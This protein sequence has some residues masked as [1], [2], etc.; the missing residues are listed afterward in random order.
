MSDV[1]S[2]PSACASSVSRSPIGHIDDLVLPWG[3]VR[4]HF[5][6]IVPS[7]TSFLLLRVRVVR[8]V[9]VTIV[10]SIACEI[11]S[12]TLPPPGLDRMRRI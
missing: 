4:T 5:G 1:P 12:P 2:P 7:T 3:P 6:I 9:A 10:V 11:A 8:E